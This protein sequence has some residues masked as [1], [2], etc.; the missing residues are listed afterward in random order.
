MTNDNEIHLSL[1]PFIL[2]TLKRGLSPIMFYYALQPGKDL[3]FTQ[4]HCVILSFIPGTRKPGDELLSD[5][6][7]W[8]LIS[9]IGQ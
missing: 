7:F 2:P 6:F 5:A 9:V 8:G 3:G 1:T 4:V